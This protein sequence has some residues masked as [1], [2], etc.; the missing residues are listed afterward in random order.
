MLAALGVALFSAAPWSAEGVPRPP[1]PGVIDLSD[2]WR[3]Q[4]P[5]SAR[6]EPVR[7]PARRLWRHLVT[8]PGRCWRR[9]G[10]PIVKLRRTVDVPA[11]L[12]GPRAAL[13]LGAFAG[14][15]RVWVG[16]RR[17]PIPKR[18][19]YV[20]VPGTHLAPGPNEL[21]LEVS[22]ACWQGGLQTRGVP[23]LGPLATRERGGFLAEFRSRQDE[24][25]QPYAVY[26]PPGWTPDAPSPVVVGLHGQNGDPTSFTYMSL[27]DELDRRGW[28]GLF[29]HGRG[30]SLYLR[31]GEI[32]VLE[33]LEAL[34]A[35]VRVDDRRVYVT[36]FSMGGT[37]SL[38][39]ALR[40]PHVF[41]A[42]AAYQGDARFDVA[43]DP[44]H[45]AFFRRKRWFGGDLRMAR[46]YSP[47]EL[48]YNA[49]HV[50]IF[51]GQGT[52]DTISPLRHAYRLRDVARRIRGGGRAGRRLDLAI[53]PGFDHEQEVIH[54]TVRRAFALF[55]S[56]VAPASPERVAHRSDDPSAARA[57]W[58]TL[59]PR[60]GRWAQADVAVDRSRNRVIVHDAA[61]TGVLEIDGA[62]A[63]LD[64]ARAIELVNRTKAAVRV[65][66]RGAA[67]AVRRV[68]ARGRARVPAGGSGCESTTSTARRC[69]R[70]PRA[71]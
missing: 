57:Y 31:K 6:W 46:R 51:F 8:G 33:A 37:G 69:V 53:L 16:D 36:G 45:R 24:T 28:V 56:V 41:A 55:D 43:F 68:P 2:G 30:A 7:L 70:L 65:R 62:G 64:R 49:L 47:E 12:A 50:P 58:L 18:T 11:E 10:H 21:R 23:R 19:W 32:D 20:V 15:V 38:T 44:G 27:L 13:H 22:F 61:H 52:A 63:G 34:R 9:R 42:V 3:L 25:V 39:T 5:R 48:L 67:D 40:R 54:L 14:G 35:R 4:A 59:A 66:V 26:L 29:P 17:V 71:W 1:A 60:S